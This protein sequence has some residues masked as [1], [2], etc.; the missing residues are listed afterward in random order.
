MAEECF[1]NIRTVKSFAAEPKEISFFANKNKQVY[2]SGKRMS[3]VESIYYTI[4][5]IFDYLAMIVILW[6]GGSQ[7]LNNNVTVG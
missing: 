3:I 5:N 6:Y 1:S 4:T 7:V 2:K